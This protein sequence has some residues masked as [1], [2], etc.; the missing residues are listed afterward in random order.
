VIGTDGKTI[1]RGIC[2]YNEWQIRAVKGLSSTEVVKRVMVEKIEV[3]H[4]DEW[5]TYM[6]KGVLNHE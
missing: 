2:N 3:I 4:R 1:G 5:M 6:T